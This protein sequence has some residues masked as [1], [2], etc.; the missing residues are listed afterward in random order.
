MTTVS[1]IMTRDIFA[2]RPETDLATTAKLLADHHISGAPVI[3]AEQRPIGVV[4]LTDLADP[5][6]ERSDRLGESK[7][8][9]LTERSRS[10]H[11]GDGA[12]TA[13]GVV[14]DVMSRFVISIDPDASL[15]RAAERMLSDDVHRLL[16]VD[17]GKLVGVV[18]SMD[19]IR[20][21]VQHREPGAT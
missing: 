6:R 11:W 17:K 2:V 19:I 5:V 3:D 10:I 9:Y 7:F 13:E 14:A 18:S 12:V 16:V 21:F 1:A 20:G 15:Q 8:Y 4:T